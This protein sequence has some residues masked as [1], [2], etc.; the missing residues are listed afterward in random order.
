MPES[1]GGCCAIRLA[2]LARYACLL[3][4]LARDGVAPVSCLG[5][6]TR[7]TGLNPPS[8]KLRRTCPSLQADARACSTADGVEPVPPGEETEGVLSCAP[9]R[10]QD[11]PA[12]FGDAAPVALPFAPDGVAARPLLGAYNA[13]DGVEPVPPGGTAPVA[14]PWRN[15]AMVSRLRTI[16]R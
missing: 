7:R 4:M 1:G 6:T 15:D 11:A 14:F 8:L 5:L 9:L 13:A 16:P 12:T 2:C 3:C 10:E